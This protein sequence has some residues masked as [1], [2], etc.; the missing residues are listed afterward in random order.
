M[1]TMENQLAKVVETD[2]VVSEETESK[3]TA[4]GQSGS[5]TNVSEGLSVGSEGPIQ[6]NL[7][8]GEG[9]IVWL[10]ATMRISCSR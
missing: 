4:V 5:L 2:D 10:C 1:P 6:R 9:E 7:L 3:V 8:G